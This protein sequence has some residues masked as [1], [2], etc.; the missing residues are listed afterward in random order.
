MQQLRRH[1]GLCLGRAQTRSLRSLLQPRPRALLA[2]RR[3]RG[4]I[5]E[6]VRDN[7][8]RV[9]VA[10]SPNGLD[11]FVKDF[12]ILLRSVEQRTARHKEHEAGRCVARA[13]NLSVR[14]GLQTRAELASHTE[15]G[16]SATQAHAARAEL[17]A[18]PP[19]RSVT[20]FAL[21]R[22]L[23]K[24]LVRAIRALRK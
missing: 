19:A 3:L 18:P 21:H 17:V 23:V 4:L 5:R 16:G 12:L 10:V 1:L 13:M 24:Q 8:A 9:A 22:E 14:R 15:H 6:Q 11:L 2:R 20:A 7:G